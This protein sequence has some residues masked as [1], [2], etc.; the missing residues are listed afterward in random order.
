MK[1][2]WK[3]VCTTSTDNFLL[4]YWWLRGTVINTRILSVVYIWPVLII[5]KLIS[6]S[7]W[8]IYLCCCFYC[9]K[10]MTF[11]KNLT[12]KKE[13]CYYQ[14][15]SYASLKLWIVKQLLR[16]L[17]FAKLLLL[18]YLSNIIRKVSMTKFR[19]RCFLAYLI[20]NC[21]FFYKDEERKTL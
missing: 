14:N 21:F 16:G 3:I 15:N 4:N 10:V 19:M 5:E 6:L 13:E 17:I 18:I 11:N 12:I 2:G 1:M 7:S 9:D 20:L 8:S